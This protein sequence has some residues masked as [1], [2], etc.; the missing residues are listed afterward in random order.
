MLVMI[1]QTYFQSD[2]Y[3]TPAGI[4]VYLD[5]IIR[6]IFEISQL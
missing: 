6:L 3:Y 2:D 4:Q 5:K 1:I